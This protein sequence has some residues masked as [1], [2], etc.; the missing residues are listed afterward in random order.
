ML[1]GIKRF[2]VVSGLL[3][4]GAL[5]LV[6]VLQNSQQS[7][8]QFLLW[9][10]PELPFSVVL[11]AAFLL[12]VLSSLLFSLILAWRMAGRSAR[13]RRETQVASSVAKSN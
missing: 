7:Q 13:A 12:G 1:S 9:A 10:T 11:V 2:I 6:F 5:V 3:L 8:F 4:V